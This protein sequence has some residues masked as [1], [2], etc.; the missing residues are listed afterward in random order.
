MEHAFGD[1]S[2]PI[3]P[4]NNAYDN[5]EEYRV[6]TQYETPLAIKL[7]EDVRYDHRGRPYQVPVQHVAKDVGGAEY[8]RSATIECVL[9]RAYAETMFHTYT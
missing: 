3:L 5:T 6:I 4:T 8:P 2:V 7:G 1:P 9:G